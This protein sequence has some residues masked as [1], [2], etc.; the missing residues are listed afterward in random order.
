MPYLPGTGQYDLAINFADNLTP[1][2]K[3]SYVIHF[4]GGSLLGA[5]F[6]ETARSGVVEPACG[7]TQ[8]SQRYAGQ[9]PEAID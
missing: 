2:A 9:R 6:S 3:A 8:Q 5:R 7:R 4:E 1:I